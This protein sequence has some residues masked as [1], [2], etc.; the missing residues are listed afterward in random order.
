MELGKVRAITAEAKYLEPGE[1]IENIGPESNDPIP[2]EIQ[3]L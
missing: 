1:A 2:V 3:L